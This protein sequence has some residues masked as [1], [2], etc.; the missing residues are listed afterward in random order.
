MLLFESLRI[1]AWFGTTAAASNV[2]SCSDLVTKASGLGNL[3][4]VNST[5]VNISDAVIA[6][7]TGLA[8]D[9]AFCRV[10]GSVS[11][12]RNYSSQ[13]EIWLPSESSWNNRYVAV[14]TL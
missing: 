12:G 9:V 13:V 11:Y 3:T 14:G 10:Q 6:N 1:L 2:L 7:L 5:A 4:L 8:N